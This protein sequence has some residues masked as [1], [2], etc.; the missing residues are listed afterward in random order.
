LVAALSP[1]GQRGA[2][3][4]GRPSA[5][6][7]EAHRAFIVEQIKQTPHLTLHRLKDGLAACGVKVS[8]NTIWQFLRREGPSFKKTLVVIGRDRADIPRGAL[9]LALLRSSLCGP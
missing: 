6:V 3:P 5:A 2:G 4:D 1:D 8:H 9:I 7:L